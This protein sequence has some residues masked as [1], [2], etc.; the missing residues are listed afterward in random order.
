M[1]KLFHILI[2]LILFLILIFLITIILIIITHFIYL[3]VVS[4]LPFSCFSF[5][6]TCDWLSAKIHYPVRSCLWDN[7]LTVNNKFLLLFLSTYYL[8]HPH[9]LTSFFLQNFFSF[10]RIS[11][12]F[13]FLFLSSFI[14]FCFKKIFFSSLCTFSFL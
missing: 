1:F 9:P 3:Y 14:F 8:F 6:L 2:F 12:E 11:I 10:S 4:F 7:L 13:P 5:I